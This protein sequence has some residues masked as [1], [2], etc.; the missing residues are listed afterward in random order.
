[1]SG[2]SATEEVSRSAR[3]GDS[4][5]NF[6]GRTGCAGNDRRGT[7]EGRATRWRLTYRYHRVRH[8]SGPM[9]CA[10]RAPRTRGDKWTRNLQNA[11]VTTPGT[12]PVS[13]VIANFDFEIPC[14]PHRWRARPRRGSTRPSLGDGYLR[15]GR[16]RARRDAVCPPSARARATPATPGRRHLRRHRLRS[17]RPGSVAARLWEPRRRSPRAC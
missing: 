3:E 9:P 2:R 6:L 1:M 11:I 12:K 5:R 10:H 8:G 16:M 7:R 13:R 4:L 15:V 17:P 14:N